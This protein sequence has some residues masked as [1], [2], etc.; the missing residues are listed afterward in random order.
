MSDIN[1]FDGNMPA[2][3]NNEENGV[4]PGFSGNTDPDKT[5][6]SND[7]TE[8]QNTFDSGNHSQNSF[9]NDSFEDD[10]SFENKTVDSV[11]V[12]NIVP[13]KTERNMGEMQG[14]PVVESAGIRYNADNDSKDGNY[15]WQYC[16]NGEVYRTNEKPEKKKKGM[17]IFGAVFVSV[18]G[19]VILVLA[20]VLALRYFDDRIDLD[21][22]RYGF[23][24]NYNRHDNNDYPIIG[25]N[26]DEGRSEY[27]NTIVLPE[28]K[29]GE[30]LSKQAIAVKCKPSSVGIEVSATTRTYYGYSYKTSGVGSGFILTE[31]GYVATNSHVVQGADE[32]TVMLDDG[33]KYK[34]EIIGADSVT[35]L[36]VIK[37]EATGLIPMEIGDSDIMLVGDSVIAIGTPAGIEFAGTV[38]DGI[39]SAINRDIEVQD[40]NGYTKTMTLMQTNAAINP[41]NSGGPLINDRGQVIGINTLKL[42]EKYEGI[43]FSI[44]I[45]SAVNIFNQLIQEGKVTNY[46]YSFVTGNGAIGITKYFEVSEEESE[47]YGIPQGIIIGLLEKNSSAYEEGLRSGDIITA[48]NGE[49]VT[50][51]DQL[52]KLKSKFRAGDE[53]TL[54]IYRDKTGEMEITFRLEVMR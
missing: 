36:A 28:L 5:I 37:I 30:T 26:R 20:T 18:L 8:Q 21:D 2:G 38:T 46:D 22:G 15:T 24:D 45:N 47:Y 14:R 1:K 54:T 33:T 42:T 40:E 7:E 23:E 49:K 34:A 10:M 29:E 17:K 19:V 35:D 13:E 39:I 32:I 50:T 43:G 6:N 11:G 3:E 53:V 25:G 27:N 52:N 16:Q 41:G 51:V 4:F 48:F 9:V 12:E 44:P 31:D